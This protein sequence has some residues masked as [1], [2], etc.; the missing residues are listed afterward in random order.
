M[1]QYSVLIG[2][3]ICFFII[4]VVSSRIL[5]SIQI[6]G[7]TLGSVWQMILILF[8][9]V[10]PVI[11]IFS[12]QNRDETTLFNILLKTHTNDSIVFSMLICVNL[13]FIFYFFY[14]LNVKKNKVT[15][16]K[17]RINLKFSTLNSNE[18][19]KVNEMSEK[20]VSK[21]ADISL[22]LGLLSIIGLIIASGGISSYLALGSVTRG[23]E[24]DSSMYINSSLLPLITLSNI[25]IISPYLYKY[26]LSFSTQGR[27]LN[28]KYILSFFF[29]LLYLFY[30]QGRL[31]LILFVI[32][33]VLDLKVTKRVKLGG[34][35]VL[36][37][38]SFP[39]LNLLTSVFNYITYGVWTFESAE[40]ILQTLLLEFTYPFS[41]FINK[42]LLVDVFGYRLGVDYVQWPFL[43][44][45]SSILRVF[46]I[47]K[48]N[49]NTIGSLNTE[50]YSNILFMQPRGGIPV[51]FFTFNY[52]QFGILS[53]IIS[54]ILFAR[55]FKKIDKRIVYLLNNEGFR[56]IVLRMSFLLV[57][58]SNNFDFSVIFRMRYDILVLI[59]VLFYVY[60]QAILYEKEHK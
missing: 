40:N 58:L 28:I 19:K 41:N 2:I 48:A 10:V 56:I 38:V 36:V 26:L 21:I 49:F 22:L 45:P 32:P 20:R 18:W 24:K 31:P 27:F 25:I 37:L 33:F 59:Y 23:V 60:S 50:A 5:K 12:N 4:L 6:Y 7:F 11:Y 16:S 51:D 8:Y 54:I 3:L 46:G 53:L 43:L 39:L 34:L 9:F 35:V 1:I 57:S 17:S 15:I 42:N 14:E 44:I 52:Y 13:I 55:L 30:N 29:S 47:N